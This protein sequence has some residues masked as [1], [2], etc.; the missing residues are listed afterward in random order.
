MKGVT[1][2][3][4]SISRLH[5]FGIKQE[6]FQEFNLP[7]GNH[8]LK[9]V[10]VDDIIYIIPEDLEDDT[11]PIVV[12]NIS[13]TNPIFDK[14]LPN[15]TM[16][17][18]IIA[19][20]AAHFEAISVIPSTWKPWVE[21]DVLSFFAGN[22]HK[23]KGARLHAKKNP[24]GS[25]DLFVFART[26]KTV[27]FQE[28]KTANRIYEDARNGFAE[29]ILSE[30]ALDSGTDTS[31]ITLTERLPHGFVQGADIEE[32]YESK[33]TLEQRRFVELPYEGPVRLKGS[34]G[35][36][37]TIALV[38]K[39]LRDGLRFQ[40]AENKKTRLCF[41]AH[42]Q[43]AVDLVRAIGEGLISPRTFRE[44]AESNCSI[45]ILTLYDLAHHYLNFSLRD[46]TPVSLDGVEGRHLQYEFIEQA[47][48]KSQ[49][50]KIF[51]SRYS[52]MYS[53][54]AKRWADAANGKDKSFIAELM[55][56][57]SSVI[58]A[59][60]I[61][62]G[63]ESGDKYIKRQKRSEWLISLP[64]EIDRRF[65]LDVHA[66][67]RQELADLDALSIDEMVADFDSFLESNA[68][69]RERARQGY[70]ALFID[71]LHLFTALEKQTL[72]KMIKR[73]YDGDD[74][75]KRPNVFMA[76]DVKQSPRDSFLDYFAADG[77]ILSAK[78]GLQ[79]KSE[80]Q[81]RK[82]FR[83]TPQIAEFL[84]DLD[85]AFPAIDI[86]GDWG[87][88]VGEAELPDDTV[89]QLK[90]YHGVVELLEA[91]FR[92]ASAFARKIDGGGRRVAVLCASDEVFE[93]YIPP[94][95]GR[96]KSDVYLVDSRDATSELRHVGRRFIFSTPEY[97]AG[98]QFDTVYLI[99]VNRI[100][101]PKSAGIGRR[102]QFISNLYLG[103]SRAENLLCLVSCEE[104]G[105]PSDVL[106][107]ALDRG[108][109]VEVR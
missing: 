31:G 89:P 58:D 77:T 44:L 103:A 23:G 36:G 32:W 87:A 75:P 106:D 52:G 73:E 57:F 91:V 67:Y 96:F 13:K 66:L 55:N 20:S 22:F 108:S 9:R 102:R 74:R 43:S 4:E 10:I 90:R 15:A 41:I 49:H 59:E 61:R 7:K 62:R 18:R 26:K 78:T 98:L 109:L 70:D 65:I 19:A 76:Y 5:R 12:L 30:G 37:K 86:P 56:E 47:L 45:E 17:D 51:K 63:E 34:A 50:S 11:E 54:L 35:T 85:A 53:V 38:I 84:K 60:N 1:F 69:D 95:K 83:Y 25:R 80:V 24:S 14:G 27:G 104:R 97:V 64:N 40:A 107:L 8:G 79:T 68:W 71:E 93:K 88:Y 82:V 2:T 42:S 105:G 33:L 16:L 48:Q 92:E 21:N 72:Q 29:A 81:L 99:H 100:E 46:L 6:W 3:R 39:M 101:A 94:A 28:I